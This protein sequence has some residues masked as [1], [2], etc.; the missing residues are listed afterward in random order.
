MYVCMYVSL[1]TSAF[2]TADLRFFIDI[3]KLAESEKNARFCF[4][5][6]FKDQKLP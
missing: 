2:N 5:F 6:L 1:K 3:R 4:L